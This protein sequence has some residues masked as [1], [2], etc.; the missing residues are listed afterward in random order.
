MTLGIRLKTLAEISG[1]ILSGN[2]EIE[3]ASAAPIETACAGQITF[4]ANKKYQRF[5]AT[6][7][8]SAVVL[9]DDVTFDRIPVIH[10]KNPYLAFALILDALYPPEEPILKG[11]DPSAI[12][13]A[14]A[15]IGG[16]YSIGALSF[17]GEDTLIGENAFIA[18]QVHI[19]NRV[20]IGHDCRLYPGVILLD[21]TKLGNNV[22]IHGGTVVGAD[23]F[24]YARHE[25]GIKKVKQVGWVEIDSEV[26]IGANCTIDR[27]ALGPTKIGRGCKIDNLVQIAHNVEL[28]ENCIIV[29]QVGISGSTRLGNGVILAG[30]VGLVGHI[31]LGDGVMV[32]AQS[33]VSHSIPAG[34]SYFGYPAREIMS[35]KR[36]EACLSRLPE[37]FRRVRELE[38]KK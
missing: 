2:G 1:G 14:S 35:T 17:V 23:G 6:T 25:R 32:G 34:K 26:E 12:I 22:I 18:P 15:K 11:I 7:A 37:L 24:G 3:I 13:A 4:V 29:S 28:G 36:I 19:G 21:D 10:H 20:K 27:G 5:L 16:N 9:A 33:G 38:E 31:E 8:A 30:Q